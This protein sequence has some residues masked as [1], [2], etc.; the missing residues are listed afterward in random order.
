MAAGYIPTELKD[1]KL[2][3]LMSFQYAKQNIYPS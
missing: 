3:I 1:D 2:I